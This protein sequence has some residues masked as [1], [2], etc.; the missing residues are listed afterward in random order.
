MVA[1]AGNSLICRLALRDGAIDPASFTSIRLISGAVVLLIIFA[2]THRGRSLRS[3]GSWTSAV[4]LFLYAICFSYAYISLSA[5]AGALILFGFVQATMITVGIWSGD[6]PSLVE[7]LGWSL[8]FGGLVWLLSPGAEAPPLVGASLMAVAGIGWGL[9]SL[10]GRGESDALASTASNF[11]LSLAM[12]LILIAVTFSDAELSATGIVLAIAAGGLTSGLGYVIW[13]IALEN[14][15]AMQ[16]ALVQLSV[17]AIATAGGVLLL[18][19]PLSF[20]LVAS[21]SLVLGGIC[22]ALIRKFPQTR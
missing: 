11:T 19:E 15:S 3:H 14:L 21:G 7:W 22:L 10:R 17:P 1:F 8:A 13:Y 9:Y 18:A 6:R 20:R 5:G 12:V 2:M 4:I 16:A